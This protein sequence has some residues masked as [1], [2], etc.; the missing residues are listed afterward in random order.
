MPAVVDKDVC[1]GCELCV[2][3]CPVE[4]IA[5]SDKNVAVVNADECVDCGDCVDICPVEAITLE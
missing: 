3:S 5:M 4:A 2:N 1:T